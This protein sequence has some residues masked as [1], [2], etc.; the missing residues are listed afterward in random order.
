MCVTDFK[1]NTII[2]FFSYRLIN[3]QNWKQRTHNKRRKNECVYARYVLDLNEM[4]KKK[5]LQNTPTR[6]VQVIDGKHTTIATE[7]IQVVIL[8]CNY[9][10]GQIDFQAQWEKCVCRAENTV[11]WIKCVLPEVRRWLLR[12]FRKEQEPFF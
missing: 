2:Y 5:E 3:K 11:M 10:N 9:S 12:F 6:H 7:L 1:Q 4:K 8:N